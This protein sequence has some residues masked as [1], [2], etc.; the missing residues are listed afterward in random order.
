MNARV[1]IPDGLSAFP[2]TPADADGGVDTNALRTLVARLCAAGA[3]S[4]GLLGST[5][6]YA[7]L[8]RTERRRAINAALDEAGGRVPIVVGVGALRT[9]EAVR[10]AKDARD[11]GAVA[12]LLA[13]VSYTPLNDDEVY[14]HYRTVA[15]E[16]GLPICIYDN[17]GTTHFGFSTDL[18]ARLSRVEGIVAAKCPAGSPDETADHLAGLRTTAADGFSIGYSGDWN[19]AE[20]M[21]AGANAWYSVLAGLYPEPCVAIVRAARR[22]DADEARR[23]NA[24]LEPVWSLFRELSSLRVVYAMANATGLVRHDPPR[25]ILPLGP[26]EHDRVVRALAAAGLA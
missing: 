18:L 25:P 1:T 6:I 5:G 14:E 16:S 17:P 22:G 9:D 3:D 2:I 11:A 7:Y 21:I 24:A 26:D 23:L 19:A 12:G 20:A 8:N 10:L 13:P 15:S 4:V